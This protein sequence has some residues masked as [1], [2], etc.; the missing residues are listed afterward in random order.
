MLA[1]R[2]SPICPS[3]DM[4]PKPW[5]RS[6][7]WISE[8]GEGCFDQLLLNECADCQSFAVLKTCP[9]ATMGAKLSK[10]LPA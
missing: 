10:A 8:R 6:R 5:T 4:A 7:D 3:G 1:T 9:S 2:R